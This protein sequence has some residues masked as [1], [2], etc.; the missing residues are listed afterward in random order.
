MYWPSYSA[1]SPEARYEYLRW[2]SDI[3]QPTNLSY[4]FLYFY[5]LERHLLVGE[6]DAAVDEIVRL[7]KAHP[8]KSFIQYASQSLIIAS[9]LTYYIDYDI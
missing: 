6:Y 8:K 7:L 1:F 4:V 5:G 2:L 3:T 9:L